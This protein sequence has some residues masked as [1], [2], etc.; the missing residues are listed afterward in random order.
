MV[1]VFIGV[2]G[3]PKWRTLSKAHF[4]PE[5]LDMVFSHSVA[6]GETGPERAPG[7]KRFGS[8]VGELK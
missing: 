6:S 5:R 4:H 8:T 2:S 7:L 1:Y 3:I